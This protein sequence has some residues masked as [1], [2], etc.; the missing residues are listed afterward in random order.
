MWDDVQ[1]GEKVEACSASSSRIWIGGISEN[2]R[3]FWLDRDTFLL[4]ARVN[5]NTPQGKYIQQA[6]DNKNG[7]KEEIVREITCM[8]L[9]ALVG[10]KEN[11]TGRLRDVSYIITLIRNKENEA[12]R[13][14]AED[15]RATMR[16]ALGLG[17]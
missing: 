15:A 16:E 3:E 12:Y 13:R 2:N 6:I 10:Q 9:L 8:L 17:G 7:D 4:G 11:K 1:I 5:K 14:G